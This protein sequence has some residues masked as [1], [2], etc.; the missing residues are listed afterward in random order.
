[1]FQGKD[2]IEEAAKAI[3]HSWFEKAGKSYE[4][5]WVSDIRTR[6]DG[7]GSYWDVTI[8][9]SENPKEIPV[10][11]VVFVSGKSR[12]YQK[13]ECA[14]RVRTRVMRRKQDGWRKKRRKE[15]EDKTRNC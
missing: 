1:M 10:P 12:R 3:V 2:F 13:V 15:G 6:E 4:L 11:Y 9:E 7:E 14:S 8:R 5:V